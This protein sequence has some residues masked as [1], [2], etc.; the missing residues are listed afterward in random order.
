MA[1][2]PLFMSLAASRETRMAAKSDAESTPVQ[3]LQ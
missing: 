3:R 2:L 1:N